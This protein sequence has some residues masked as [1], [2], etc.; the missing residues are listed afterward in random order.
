[1]DKRKH[2]RLRVEYGLSVLG[3]SIRGQGIVQDLSVAGCRARSP[4]DV[5]Q[6]DSIS[7]LIDVP[8]Y[9]RPLHVDIAIVRW[10]KQQEF[11]M[12]FIR[13]APDYQQRLQELIRTSDAHKTA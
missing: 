5:K 8:R 7:L 9:E 12:E 11:G 6:G 13:M 1:M 2:P 3:E 4:V 10:A